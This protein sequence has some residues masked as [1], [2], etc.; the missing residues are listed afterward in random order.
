MNF[1]SLYKQYTPSFLGLIGFNAVSIF[2]P[3]LSP[4]LGI[5]YHSREFIK[6]IDYTNS[7]KKDIEVQL[8]HESQPIAI[9]C[10]AECNR[11]AL[12]S[13]M[14]GFIGSVIDLG[15]LLAN[16]DA[17]TKST[18]KYSCKNKEFI[19]L[20]SS[21]LLCHSVS[22]ILGFLS[23]I[24]TT[25]EYDFIDMET[26]INIDPY[27]ISHPKTKVLGFLTKVQHEDYQ[28]SSDLLISSGI[29][30]PEEIETL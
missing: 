14:F 24:S 1:Q 3:K 5:W 7:L 2:Y 25:E 22:L 4:F 15:S 9:S 26:G 19:K 28:E 10:K 16:P 20:L 12:T 18:I 17:Y 21:S 11:A 13:N 30:Q 6:N 27:L 8:S 23:Y 29:I